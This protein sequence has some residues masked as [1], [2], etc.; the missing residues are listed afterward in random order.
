[1]FYISKKIV[2]KKSKSKKDS[3]LK[4]KAKLDLRELISDAIAS[5]RE[6]E[7]KSLEQRIHFFKLVRNTKKREEVKTSTKEKSVE[8]SILDDFKDSDKD[9]DTVISV[10]YSFIEDEF[11]QSLYKT[12][13]VDYLKMFYGDTGK[14]PPEFAADPYAIETVNL[15][16]DS[17]TI[18]THDAEETFMQVQYATMMGAHSEV[19]FKDRNKL[20]MWIKFN[21]DLFGVFEHS[22]K[23]TSE[24]NYSRIG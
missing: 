3:I 11:I 8:E 15:A 10:D 7:H 16:T 19:S 21:R 12:A 4:N 23:L 5:V 2:K 6:L 17:E 9:E 14:V 1:V 20:D 22:R 13:A 24:V 18:E